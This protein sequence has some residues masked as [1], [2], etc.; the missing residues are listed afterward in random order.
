MNDELAFMVV[1]AGDVDVG[2]EAARVQ[3]VIPLE[4]WDGEAALELAVV[5]GGAADEGAAR[6][7][8]VTRPGREPLAALVSGAVV[9]RQVP[10]AQLLKVPAPLAGH[11]RWVSHVVVSEGAGGAGGEGRAMLVV[12]PDRLGT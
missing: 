3:E 8:V 1:R 4:R 2:I 12:D 5:A 11:V 6:I 9:L 10:R 7:L